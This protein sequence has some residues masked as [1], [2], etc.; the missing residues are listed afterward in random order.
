VT[1]PVAVVTGAGGGIGG[2]C[3]RALADTHHV[4]CVDLDLQRARVTA[5][6]VCESGGAA[7]AVVADAEDPDFG[8]LIAEAS[9]SVGQ[10]R[11]AVHAVAHEEHIPAVE[12]S[13]ASMQRSF[14]VGPLAAFAMFRALLRTC[15]PPPGSA[16]TVIG[17]LHERHAFTRCLGYNAAHGAL[18]QVVRTL[19][20]EWAERRI[21]VNAVVPGWIATPGEAAFY[22][23]EQLARAGRALPFGRLG[24]VDEIA[25]AVAFVSSPAAGYVSG[26]FFTVDGA[27]SVSLARLPEG[28]AG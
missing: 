26:S 7:T 15:S 25:K 18:G 20:H 17:S 19:A 16:F 11:C 28:E 10:L 9:A 12:L 24:D 3:A 14:A 27:L 6:A 4:V 2:A 1:D 5:T 21:R 22:S 23:E 13:I 8:D